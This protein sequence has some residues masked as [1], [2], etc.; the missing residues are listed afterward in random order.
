MVSFLELG[1]RVK[2]LL[3]FVVSGVDVLAGDQGK[4]LVLVNER[5]ASI[6]DGVG[7]LSDEDN[8]PGRSVVVLRVGP[9]QQD[10]VHDGHEQVRDLSE[11]LGVLAKGIEELRQRL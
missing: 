8:K 2:S 7:D 9:D 3:K 5:L 10:G 6:D 11:V 1:T 4:Y